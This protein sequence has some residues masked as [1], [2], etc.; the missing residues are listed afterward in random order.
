[1][2]D[3]VL[4]NGVT[5]DINE[6]LVAFLRKPIAKTHVLHAMEDGRVYASSIRVSDVAD[7]GTLQVLLSNPSDSIR[8]ICWVAL[9]IAS[10]G[11]AYVDMYGQ[12]T[13]DTP[14]TALTQVQKFS[15]SP[16]ASVADTEYNGAYSYTAPHCIY[17]ALLPGGSGP[18]S[19]GGSATDAEL[20][21]AIPGRNVLI[22]LTNKA[23]S[24][25][26]MSLRIVWIDRETVGI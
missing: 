12:V 21:I 23:G 15:G 5:Y 17:Q 26:D 22:V 11:K 4:L 2:K 7:D 10:E 25:K 6:Y 19:I 18:K 3:F 16:K 20:A 9:V 1:M 13:V 24:A 14:G 8:N